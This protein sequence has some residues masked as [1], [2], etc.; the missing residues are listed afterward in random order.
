MGL[1]YL[2]VTVNWKSPR[3]WRRATAA[4]MVRLAGVPPR[5]AAEWQQIRREMSPAGLKRKMHE[6]R[7]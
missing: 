2:I 7:N 1:H 3:V 4:S 6:Q 5:V